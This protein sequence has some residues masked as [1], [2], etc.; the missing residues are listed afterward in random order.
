MESPE[1]EILLF[2]N[3]LKINCNSISIYLSHQLSCGLD[4]IQV[5]DLDLFLLYKKVLIF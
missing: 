4:K 2:S 3:D 1:Y 5:I